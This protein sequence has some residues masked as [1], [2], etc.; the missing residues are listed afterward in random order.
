MSVVYLAINEKANKTWAVKELRKDKRFETGFARE[1][2]IAETELL[3]KLHHPFLPGIADVIEREDNLLIV[4]DYVEGRSLET[5]LQEQGALEQE[6]V[7]SLGK[8]LCQVLEYLHRQ[9]PPVIYRDMKPSNIM[10]QPDGTIKL[11]DFGTAREWKLQ[12]EQED[13][14]CLGTPGYAAPEQWGG[15]GQT[16]IRTDIYGLG[17]TLYHLLTGHC[18]EGV[19]SERKPVY[20]WNPRLSSGLEEILQRCTKR[21]PEERYQ[22]CE[23]VQEALEYYR[24]MDK[25]HRR[26]R[27]RKWRMFL[28][29]LVLAVCM[30]GSSL[31]AYGKAEKLRKET[32][33]FWMEQAL[34]CE[35]KNGQM[36]AYARAILTAPGKKE[37][38]LELLDRVFLQR[39]SDGVIRFTREEDEWLRKLLGREKQGK[40]CEELLEKERAA[41][42]QVSYRLGLAYFYDYEGKGQKAYALRWLKN[43]AVSEILPESCTERAK[44]LAAIA[45]YYARIGQVDKAGDAAVSYLDY[46]KDLTELT[47]GNLVLMDNAVTALRMYQECVSQICVR[48]LEFFQAGVTQREM[49]SKLEEIESHLRTDFTEQDQKLP[50]V[51][52]MMERLAGQMEEAEWQVKA[53]ASYEEVKEKWEKQNR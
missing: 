25:E 24:E 6:E 14:V 41:Y 47:Q 30:G 2:L 7:V 13:T 52:E 40:T 50:G 26:A 11:I 23:E 15:N 19:F 21:N 49:E 9:N 20:F 43:A 4:M 38:Y 1:R 48:A 31:T 3:K 46:W 10:L 36:E 28:T 5:L 29:V 27:R 45:N 16:D 51:Q 17:E 8:Q 34:S 39:D 44:R 53:V 35:S 22:S 18:P 32:W 33:Q 37:G 42:D 12:E